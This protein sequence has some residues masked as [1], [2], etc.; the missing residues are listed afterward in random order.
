MVF[1]DF[2]FHIFLA[3]D[4]DKVGEK[5]RKHEETFPLNAECFT[6]WAFRPAGF[7]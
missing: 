2:F 1:N 6:L 5:G 3:C 7:M 4:S